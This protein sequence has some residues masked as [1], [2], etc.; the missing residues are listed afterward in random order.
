MLGSFASKTFWRAVAAVASAASFHAADAR[1]QAAKPAAYNYYFVSQGLAAR[2]EEKTALFTARLDQA[3]PLNWRPGPKLSPE[4]LAQGWKIASIRCDT[5]VSEACLA[6]LSLNGGERRAFVEID[7]SRPTIISTPAAKLANA[8]VLAFDA[9]RHQAWL[10]A[11]PIGVANSDDLASGGFIWSTQQNLQTAAPL[12]LEVGPAARHVAT[13]SRGK[14][15]TNVLFVNRG[16]SPH[17]TVYDDKG[18]VTALTAA[19]GSF[20]FSDLAGD[21]FLRK[22]TNTTTLDLSLYSRPRRPDSEVTTIYAAEGTPSAPSLAYVDGSGVAGDERAIV[23]LRSGT[24]LAIVE[25]DGKRALRELCRP[26]K[27][28]PFEARRRPE[29]ETTIAGSVDLTLLNMGQAPSGAIL[30]RTSPAG[31]LTQVLVQ[32]TTAIT[33]PTQGLCGSARLRVHALPPGAEVAADL[34]DEER[35]FGKVDIRASQAV[36]ADGTVISYV[37]IGD[38][39]KPGR[40]MVRVYGAYGAPTS[41][42]LVS[43]LEREW[44]AAGNTIVAPTL[45]G[46]GGPTD[47]WRLNG[48][49]DYKKTTASDLNT[50]VSHLVTTGLA[51][52]GQIILY[53]ASAGAFTAAR[54]ALQHPDRYSAIVLVSGS[55]DLSRVAN[56]AAT[57]VHEIGSSKGSFDDWYGAPGSASASSPFFILAHAKN[58]ERVAPANTTAFA[59]YLKQ[60]GYKGALIMPERGGHEL[61]YYADFGQAVLS[62]L[63][64][65]Q[66]ANTAGGSRTTK[67]S[68]QM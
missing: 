44:V 64:T 54:E 29:I 59:G 39:S 46:D 40:T 43:P 26:T 18:S 58:D 57:D 19:P 49:G 55:L 37:M 36:A 13:M 9:R 65:G 41:R 31:I 28:A 67:P 47:A 17:W 33:S 1:A 2:L 25:A 42:F 32:D 21:H 14:D 27:N 8:D 68:A 6:G 35:R 5:A 53:G 34:N 38:P 66:N 10:A 16:P 22:K 45:R 15:G 20:A 50:V 30:T 51:Q 56:D 4:A 48:R 52:N 24:W 63:S 7:L 61:Q 12:R 60:K 23:R 11:R 3:A 62:S